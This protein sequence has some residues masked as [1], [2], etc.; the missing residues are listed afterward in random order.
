MVKENNND[1]LVWFPFSIDDHVSTI[2]YNLIP[3]FESSTFQDE[4]HFFLPISISKGG[5]KLSQCEAKQP[6]RDDETSRNEQLKRKFSNHVKGGGS[7]A[8][9]ESIIAKQR[10]LVFNSFK[11]QFL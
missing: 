2:N 9:Y 3:T 5:E 8:N 10:I 11:K 6:M 1:Q 7:E 4:R